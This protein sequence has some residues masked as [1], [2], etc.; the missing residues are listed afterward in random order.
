MT[1]LELIL[2]WTLFIVSIVLTGVGI[3]TLV[4]ARRRR[5]FSENKK[6]KVKETKQA[7]EVPA[8]FS[9]LEKLAPKDMQTTDEDK[10]KRD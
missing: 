3:G 1:E 5:G 8:L 9:A 6:V 10:S 4:M 2:Y 7:A